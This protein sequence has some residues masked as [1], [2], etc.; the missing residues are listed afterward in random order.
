[1][2][3]YGAITKKKII[4]IGAILLIVGGVFLFFSP[5]LVKKSALLQKS[6]VAKDRDELNSI[7]EQVIVEGFLSQNNKVL[8]LINAPSEKM[9]IYSLESKSRRSRRSSR[10]HRRNSS[11]KSD[12]WRTERCVL[13]AF[14]L[15]I[16]GG[17]LRVNPKNS[18][19]HL[20]SGNYR[21][22]YS[23]YRDYRTSWFARGDKISVLVGRSGKLFYGYD[24]HGGT[25]KEWKDH[26][27]KSVLI[28]R[29]GSLAFLV[30][31]LCLIIF[32]FLKSEK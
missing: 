9:V 24:Y 18:M 26:A 10:K 14:N 28:F 32:G 11:K 13:P 2:A 16:A 15:D 27:K 31:G 6:S 21:V 20:P 17:V 30:I 23:R 19:K 8:S 12:S 25:A 29:Y 7:T 22:D 5:M 1:M 3:V 4:T